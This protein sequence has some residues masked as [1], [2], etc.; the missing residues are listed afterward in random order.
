MTKRKLVP[1]LRFV[2]ALCAG[3]LAIL[4]AGAAAPAAQISPLLFSDSASMRA[5]AL[6]S[7]TLRAE[8]FPQTSSVK[9]NLND[10]RT[11]IT[12]FCMNLDLLA[13]EGANALTADAEDAA[14]NH[15]SLNV[16]YVGQ[17][18]PLVDSNGN[19]TSDFRG[20]YMVIV[21]LNDLMPTELGDV[22]IRLNLN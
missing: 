3:L 20:I 11:R 13:G 4:C 12:L 10:T 16:E 14:H 18:P 2:S 5:I 9:F 17:V 7:V 21:R 22:L 19:I 6:E 1:R 15:Y 8:P